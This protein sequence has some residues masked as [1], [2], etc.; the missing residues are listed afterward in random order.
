[1]AER[2]YSERPMW[3]IS[4][5]LLATLDKSGV[6]LECN[7]A[8]A[9]VLDL[10]PHGVEGT[11]FLDYVH[12]ED[13]ETTNQAI[14]RILSGEIVRRFENRY[15]HRDGTYRWLSWNATPEG[16]IFFY[17]ARDVTMEK[18]N[19]EALRS[20]E[21]EAKLR[22]QFIAVLGHDLRNPIAAVGAGARILRRQTHDP[23]TLKVIGAMEVSLDRMSG[24]INNLLDFARAQL[25]GGVPLQPDPK[26]TL[27]PVLEATVAEARLA[28]PDARF[29][30]TYAFLDPVLCDPARIAQLLSNLLANAASHGGFDKP[31]SVVGFDQGDEF[32][33]SVSNS[34]VPITPAAQ[35]RLFQPFFRAEVEASQQGLGLGLFI[36]SEIAK[37]HGGSIEL[38]SDRDETCFTLHLP[39]A[40]KAVN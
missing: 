20:S 5:E 36:S 8:W 1:M 13:L 11:A 37:A 14:A 31:V 28:F 25:G 17:S 16:E 34:G 33:L 30:E 22:D 3:K 7:P 6:F 15:R 18:A 26:T 10:D 24:L 19:I 32:C 23:E 39:R 2:P 35:K 9:E 40:P 12:P 4:T 38:R 29:A 21:N 27:R